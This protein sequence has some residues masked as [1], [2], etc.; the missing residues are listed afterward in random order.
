MNYVRAIILILSLVAFSIA[1]FF[2]QS[3]V[4]LWFPEMDLYK[5]DGFIEHLTATVFLTTSF[6]A[7]YFVRNAKGE[8]HGVPII[9]FIVGLIAFLEEIS[10][11]YHLFDFKTL[12]ILETRLDGLHD[13][14][15]IAY[16]YARY[17]F[18]SLSNNNFFLVVILI[19]ILLASLII[20]LMFIFSSRISGL[21]R[22]TSAKLIALS[23]LLMFIASI[24]DLE[25]ANIVG[26]W[27]AWEETLELWAA[28]T[29]MAAL[30]AFGFAA[31]TEYESTGQAG[32]G[33][34]AWRPA[35]ALVLL[36]SAAI[37]TAAGYAWLQGDLFVQH[38]Q[39]LIV[40]RG[41]GAS[42]QALGDVRWA[43][44]D[45][46]SIHATV[47]FPDRGFSLSMTIKPNTDEGVP[48]SHLI[49]VTTVGP[50]TF[51]G[52]GIAA[53]ANFL[54]KPNVDSS[55]QA[56]ESAIAGIGDDT[57][58]V[59]LSSLNRSGNLK[60]LQNWEVFELRFEDHAGQHGS[61]LFEKGDSG[62]RVFDAA[63]SSWAGG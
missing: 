2:L 44:K 25:I 47:V 35:P 16:K 39:A 18:A 59:A 1:T 36:V 4:R 48:A 29:L 41:P 57:F 54:M 12:L 28:C 43:F 33:S 56:L 51:A 34:G 53:L 50:L 11:G 60:L 10:Y 55:G 19:I 49:E 40:E 42:A 9:L 15:A 13:F 46:Q 14:I 8:W 6:S 27:G 32:L 24:L 38:E 21:V 3:I 58:W 23:F 52:L 20:T 61:V 62:G 37:A 17:Q 7:L 45:H 26:P 63:F 30:L 5:E 31:A 22:S